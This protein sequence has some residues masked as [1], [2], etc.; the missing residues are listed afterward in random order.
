MRAF[1]YGTRFGVSSASEAG[2]RLFSAHSVWL[3]YGT[4]PSLATEAAEAPPNVRS[5]KRLVM[6]K[7]LKTLRPGVARVAAM[8]LLASLI[9]ACA[10]NFTADVT[11]FQQL[12]KPSGETIEVVPKDPKE[13]ASLSFKQYAQMVGNH[14]GQVGYSP[15]VAGTPSTLIATIDYGI[16]SGPTPATIKKR[17]P[18][19]IGIGVGTGGRNSAFGVG[20]STGVGTAKA[21]PPVSNRWLKL[22]ITRRSD[23]QVL[24]EGSAE[25]LGESTNINPAMPLLVQALFKDFPGKSGT[26]D[27]VELGPEPRPAS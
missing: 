15:P 7:T 14:L 18:V 26:T 11:R 19:T 21:E 5:M 12:P 20:M 23:G 4:R 2:M 13:A 9:S 22:V 3:Y 1:M 25:S 6:I 24:Y 8:A 17:S 27:H 10:T 16:S